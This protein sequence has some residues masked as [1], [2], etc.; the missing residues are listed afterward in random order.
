[1]SYA[2]KTAVAVS[3]LVA[4]IALAT[5]LAAAGDRYSDAV[6]NVVSGLFGDS[7]TAGLGSNPDLSGGGRRTLLEYVA[8]KS[9]CVESGHGCPLVVL[10]PD[11]DGLRAIGVIRRVWL[12][13]VASAAKT[14]GWADLIY[15][16]DAD[17]RASRR[18][19]VARFD[20]V[21]YVPDAYPPSQETLGSQ[22]AAGKVV[23]AEPP[24]R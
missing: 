15:W 10:T 17:R 21:E 6:W 23:L 1:M 18:Y 2:S 4:A 5:E 24:N 11:G 16:A 20:G 14:N 9:I 7:A 19:A 8:G 22:A 13:V 12:P 3:S